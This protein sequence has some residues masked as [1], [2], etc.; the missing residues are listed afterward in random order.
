MDDLIKLLLSDISEAK[1]QGKFSHEALNWLNAFQ[2]RIERYMVQQG[3]SK[4]AADCPACER[5]RSEFG[6]ANYCAHCGK[7]LNIE[8]C[9]CPVQGFTV[10]HKP[11]CRF[12]E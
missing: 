2:S 12:N 1:S 5:W 8:N 9:D 7:K 10:F 4:D 11:N 3:N 6:G